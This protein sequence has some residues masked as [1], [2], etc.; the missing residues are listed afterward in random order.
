M[1]A[2]DNGNTYVYIVWHG[3]NSFQIEQVQSRM[4]FHT[5]PLQGI[6][7]SWRMSA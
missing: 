3:E 1:P 4:A 2:E 6:N 7:W 5:R